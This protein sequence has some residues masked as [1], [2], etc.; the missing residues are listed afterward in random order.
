MSQRRRSAGYPQEILAAVETGA[1]SRDA[2]DRDPAV[3]KLRAYGLRLRDRLRL[4]WTTADHDRLKL[5]NEEVDRIARKFYL[6]D[7]RG[8]L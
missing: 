5:V 2:L 8:T 6:T 7:G 3:K 4:N 1:H